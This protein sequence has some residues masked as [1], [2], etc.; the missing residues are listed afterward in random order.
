MTKRNIFSQR[1]GEGRDKAQRIKPSITLNNRRPTRVLL[2]RTP[3]MISILGNLC[4]HVAASGFHQRPASL[5][6]ES[7]ET[8]GGSAVPLA[9]GWHTRGTGAA[10]WEEGVPVLPGSK[11]PEFLG[12]PSPL[13]PDQSTSKAEKDTF[14]KSFA[15]S[16][17]CTSHEVTIVGGE[18]GRM[19]ISGL[20][21]AVKSVQ[22]L[23]CVFGGDGNADSWNQQNAGVTFEAPFQTD[24]SCSSLS[25]SRNRR[26]RMTLLSPS[27]LLQDML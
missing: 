8:R 6:L 26:P 27:P 22:L 7:S 16:E 17:I 19:I 11:L 3:C 10:G 12:A 14:V 20:L 5:P 15:N 23:S 2:L 1:V 4:S 13:T 25:Q 9:S 21:T 24:T 18:R